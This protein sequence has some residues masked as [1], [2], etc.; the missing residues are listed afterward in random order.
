MS[1]LRITEIKLSRM[2]V[3]DSASVCSK[4]LYPIS[5]ITWNVRDAW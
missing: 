4:M 1:V 5:N 3:K 2:V